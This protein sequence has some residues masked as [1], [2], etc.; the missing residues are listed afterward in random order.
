MIQRFETFCTSAFSIY[1]SIQKIER[2]EMEKFGLKGPHA[3]CLIVMGGYPQGITAVQLTEICDRDKAAIS[4][5]VSEL[6]Q[7]G[8]VVRECRN[9]TVYR[10]RLKLTEKGQEAA[11]RVS[12]LASLAV[13]Q[14]GKGLNDAQRQIFYDSLNLIAANLHDISSQGITKFNQEESL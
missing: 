11:R 1:R 12:E 6:E 7:E 8:M 4:R 2:M 10:A 13:Q 9:G 5:I 14:A 3:Q